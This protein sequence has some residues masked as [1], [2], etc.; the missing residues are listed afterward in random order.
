M[1]DETPSFDELISFPEYPDC[2]QQHA[3]DFCAELSN[4]R[5]SPQWGQLRI[6]FIDPS[7]RFV[8]K[9]PRNDMGMTANAY[10]ARAWRQYLADPRNIPMAGCRIFYA[11]PEVG[12]TMLAMRYIEQ[13]PTTINPEW[14]TLVDCGQYGHDRFGRLV[15]Y[16]L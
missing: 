14:G 7:R 16:D 13:A 4:R 11:D 10:E 3:I 9:V 1:I 15:A 5:F 12:V 6:A 2:V 8:I